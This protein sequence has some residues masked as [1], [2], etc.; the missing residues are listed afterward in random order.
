MISLDD[1]IALHQ[2]G[3]LDEAEVLYR[4]ILEND[5]TNA[6]AWYYLGML[7][8]Q[9]SALDLA[10]DA[11]LKATK[12]APEVSDYWSGLGLAAEELGHLSEALDYFNKALDLN[13]ENVDIK[14]NIGNVMRLRN[15]PDSALDV[16]NEVLQ[17]KPDDITALNNIGLI[18]ADKLMFDDAITCFDKV[19][20]KNPGYD[21][22]RYNRACALRHLNRFDEAI[23]EYASL[24]DNDKNVAEYWNGRGLALA[25]IGKYDEAISDYEQALDIKKDHPDFLFN[26]ATAL[27]KTGDLWKA[28]DVLQ[29]TVSINPKNA[30]AHA[31]FGVVQYKLGL[32][33]GAL[34]SYREAIQLEPSNVEVMNNIALILRETDEIED[35]VGLYLSA[36]YHAPDSVSISVNAAAA[37]ACMYDKSDENRD[38]VKTLVKTWSTEQPNN[39][40]ARYLYDVLFSDE[41]ISNFDGEYI[42]AVYNQYTKDFDDYTE[43]DTNTLKEFAGLITI[44]DKDLSVLDLGCGSGRLG[45][46]LRDEAKRLVGVDVSEELTA[47][48]QKIEKYDAVFNMEISE[49]LKRN[50]EQF[51]LIVMADLL[52]SFGDIAPLFSMVKSALKERGRIFISTLKG[53]DRDFF[54]G[55]DLKFRHNIEYVKKVIIEAGMEIEQYYET[56]AQKNSKDETALGYIIKVVKPYQ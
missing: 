31:N 45:R 36:I 4:K 43:E 22:A 41:V 56:V 46:V 34:E 49:F 14:I 3:L 8:W 39:V 37:L 48:A 54:L 25:A 16:Y 50:K 1:A 12:Y 30:K 52:P 29:K 27:F 35:A 51:D 44:D 5:K 19:L 40:I 24:I 7:A 42:D 38:K 13:P 10:T 32:Y 17:K 47:R 20:Q 18:Y 9:H 33:Q 15:Q 53:D 23:T 26:Y 28:H 2:Q 11:L 21:I 6:K 55:F